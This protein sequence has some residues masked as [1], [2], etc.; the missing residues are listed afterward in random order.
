MLIFQ[1][2]STTSARPDGDT[3]TTAASSRSCTGTDKVDSREGGMDGAA[4]E[5]STLAIGAAL[6]AV[7]AILLLTLVGVVTGWV[8]SRHRNKSTQK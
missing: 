2:S 4:V 1:L 5:C 7:S 3:I 6:G 8:W